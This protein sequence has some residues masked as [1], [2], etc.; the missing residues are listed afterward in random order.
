M[1]SKLDAVVLSTH[2]YIVLVFCIKV[3]YL[4]VP[5]FMQF[6]ASSECSQFE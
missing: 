2:L 6:D 3:H 4:L 1:F 5:P